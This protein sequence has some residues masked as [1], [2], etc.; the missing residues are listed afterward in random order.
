MSST[1][2]IPVLLQEILTHTDP[3]P[4]QNVFDGTLGGGGYAEKFSEHIGKDGMLVGTDLDLAA[5]SR[6]N[7]K[8]FHSQ[9]KFIHGSYAQIDQIARELG[10]TFDVAVVDLGLSSDQLDL[11]KRG[12][13]FKSQDQPLDMR[14]NASYGITASEALNTWSEESIADIL[15]GFGGEQYSRMIAKKIVEYRKDNTIETVGELVDL[16]KS[17][18]PF[19]YHKRKTHPATKTFQALRIAINTEW[20][21]IQEFLEHAPQAI[22]PGGY[23]AVVSFHSGEDKVIKHTFRRMQEQGIGTIVTKKPIKASEDEVTQNPRSRSAL[24]RIIQI[25]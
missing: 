25:Q 10:I 24:L 1:E 22:K 3:K 8:E 20:K 6:V 14:Y 9:T 23:I 5:L 11:E 16:V 4:G 21:H 2:H 17:G 19:S 15:F 13:S 12:F 18:T 7:E